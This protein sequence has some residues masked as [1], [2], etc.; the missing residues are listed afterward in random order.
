LDT[1]EAISVLDIAV[2][3]GL[4]AL[5][6]TCGW[7]LWRYRLNVGSIQLVRAPPEEDNVLAHIQVVYDDDAYAPYIFPSLSAKEKLQRALENDGN[8]D[9]DDDSNDSD[10]GEH[11]IPSEPTDEEI[12]AS[13]KKM[14][15]NEATDSNTGGND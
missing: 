4:L 11:N 8:D 9:D 10:D 13:I 5:S 12:L 2:A 6:I 15:G 3:G 14:S 1:L 7:L